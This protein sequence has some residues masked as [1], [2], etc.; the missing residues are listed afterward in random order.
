MD[1]ESTFRALAESEK[2]VQS[3]TTFD[4]ITLEDAFRAL[5]ERI[6]LTTRDLF[7]SIRIAVTG[8]TA[9]P[10]LFDTLAVLGKD[11]VLTRLK[12]ALDLLT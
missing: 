4:K 3:L 6:G 2:L 11:R 12:F 10:P 1:K 8:R 5:A 9:T 7:G